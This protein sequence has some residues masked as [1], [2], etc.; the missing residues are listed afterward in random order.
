M[1][2]MVCFVQNEGKRSAVK[3]MIQ[4][5]IGGHLSVTIKGEGKRVTLVHAYQTKE[6]SS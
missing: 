3:V 6:S 1:W 5:Q 4:M 2:W